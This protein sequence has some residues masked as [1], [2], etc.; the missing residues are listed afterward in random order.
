VAFTKQLA[1]H[2]NVQT[3]RGDTL[4]R[5]ALRELGDASRWYELANINGLKPPYIV[6]SPTNDNS[7]IGDGVLL[8]G[9]EIRIP[10]SNPIASAV[11]DPDIVFGTDVQLNRGALVSE[12]GDLALTS[13]VDNLKQAINH[14]LRTDPGELVYH[15]RYGCSVRAL[16]GD[17]NTALSGDIAPAFVKRSLLADSRISSVPQA[18]VRIEGDALVIECEAITVDGKQI[19][20]QVGNGISG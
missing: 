1:G 20:K 13:G 8:T 6:D 4:A 7:Q 10:S 2:R 12:S 19:L 18:T 15:A 5:I 3:Q 14:V 11:T 17:G 16:V 9:S